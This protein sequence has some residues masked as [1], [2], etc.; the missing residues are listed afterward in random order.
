MKKYCVILILICTISI[1]AQ[2]QTNEHSFLNK[3]E[4]KVGYYGNLLWDNGLNSGI[5]YLWKEKVVV[6]AKK[7][8]QK[9]I[10]HQF[11]FN[12]SL[13][14]ATNFA[15]KT[16]NGLHTYYGL[17]WRRTN[18]KRRQFHIEVNPLG[19]YRS[20][21]KETFEVKG[22]NVSKVKF[23]GRH[24]Y[25]PSMAIGIGRQRKEK[26]RSGWYLNFNYTLRMPYNTGVLPNFSLQYGY[27]FN[28]KNKNQ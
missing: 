12:G 22:D 28:F 19:Y 21:L 27:R 13:G 10:V 25:A 5:E 3:A 14:Y 4:F 6:K 26:R 17:I 7:K 23:P 20:F 1:H 9:I 2:N 8:G 16:D 24:Y 15:N 11:L 18:P